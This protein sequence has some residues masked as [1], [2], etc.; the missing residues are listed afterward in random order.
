MEVFNEFFEHLDWLVGQSE[1]K[2]MVLW[3][4][5]RSGI[6]FEKLLMQRYHR[7]PD[8]IID[9]ALCHTYVQMPE[10]PIYCRDVLDYYDPGDTVIYLCMLG[11]DAGLSDVNA[12]LSR[13]GYKEEVN[14]FSVRRYEL[15]SYNKK[16]LCYE[17]FLQYR[18]GFDLVDGISNPLSKSTCN[19]DAHGFTSIDM[20]DLLHILRDMKLDENS[21]FF[22]Y[23]CGKGA[24]VMAALL[25]G[26]KRAGGIEMNRNLYPVAC[27]NIQKT[28]KFIGEGY[29]TSI[30]CG[31]AS[32]LE[33]IDEYDLFYFYSPFAGETFRQTIRQI[34]RSYK[35]KPRKIRI[36]Y[37]NPRCHFSVIESGVF[38]LSRQFVI[39]TRYPCAN[40]YELDGDVCRKGLTE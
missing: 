12:E 8:C 38:R 5:G 17:S 16:G 2:K 15:G 26:V 13:R 3:G 18:K 6:F 19:Q 34:E 39:Q 1:N 7:R 29:N 27:D 37:T 31:N 28:E 32:L 10:H 23:G 11:M 25:A 35:R 9:D 40:L 4:Y 22:D 21:A 30:I 36:L 20:I 24:A 33:E 14:V